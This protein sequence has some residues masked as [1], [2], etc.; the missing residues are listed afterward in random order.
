[1]TKETKARRALL[2]S[3][4]IL[5][6]ENPGASF[7]EI[8]EYAG[9]GRAT[10]Y[11]HFSSREDLLRALS[12]EAIQIIDQASEEIYKSAK[13]AREFIELTLKAMIPLGD[14]YYFLMHLPE[15][16]DEDVKK[17]MDRQD[18]ELLELIQAAQKEG[19]LRPELPPAW[20]AAVF[21][22]LVYTTWHLLQTSEIEQEALE[23]L[24]LETLKR[25][26]F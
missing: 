7:I 25:S 10:L 9:I 6:A 23:E 16:N 26:L 1:M 3:A 13:S 2:D 21:N 15:L 20:A 4:T 17:Q 11:R 12:L 5:L 22:N 8:A 24:A 14:R 19:S 18:T